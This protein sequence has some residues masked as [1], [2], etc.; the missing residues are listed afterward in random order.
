MTNR[1]LVFNNLLLL[2]GVFTVLVMLCIVCFYGYTK[3]VLPNLVWLSS[4]VGERHHFR[5]FEMR[6]P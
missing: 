3:P 6:L 2:Q 5:L 1:I 4:P